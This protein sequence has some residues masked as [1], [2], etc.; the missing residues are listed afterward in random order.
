MT[1]HTTT[2]PPVLESY[3]QRTWH[4]LEPLDPASVIEALK[5]AGTELHTFSGN[6]GC[7][8]PTRSVLESVRIH[9]ARKGSEEYLFMKLGMILGNEVAIIDQFGR[10]I[11][12]ELSLSDLSVHAP[13]TQE[14]Q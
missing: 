2:I 6:G 7:D 9:G 12:V 4:D 1:Q 10:I 5:A 14:G 13:A 3:I 8:V 11:L